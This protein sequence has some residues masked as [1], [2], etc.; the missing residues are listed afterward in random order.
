VPTVECKIEEVELENDQG[1]NVPGVKATC[2]V[3]GH[4]TESFGTG[5]KSRKRCLV[6]MRQECP[7]GCE[8]FYKDEDA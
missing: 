4:V 2:G 6:V 5:E 1:R 8:N 3:C 7:E